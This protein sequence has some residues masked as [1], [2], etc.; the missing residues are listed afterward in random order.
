M[1]HFTVMVIGPNPENQ[2]APY[3]EDENGGFWDWYLLGGRWTGFFK[4]KPGAA[5]R[6]GEPG[7]LTEPAKDGFAD[8]AL[9]KD[10]DFDWMRKRARDVAEKHYD[11]AH[12]IISANPNVISWKNILNKHHGN[13]DSARVEYHMQPVINAFY[14]AG[15]IHLFDDPIEKFSIPREMYV[16]EAESRAICSYAF[17]RDGKWTARGEMGWFG[18][19]SN[20]MDENG[21]HEKVSA[22]LDELPEDTLISLYDCHI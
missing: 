9:K 11:K 5:G 19:S 20:E 12:A 7:V 16:K 21:W 15:L 3:E 8:A 4:L 6:I 18:V 14:G 13:I 2:L 22:M 1:S 10:I 17:V